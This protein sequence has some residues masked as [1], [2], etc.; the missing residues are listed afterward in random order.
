MLSGTLAIDT[1][2]GRTSEA[3]PSAGLSIVSE[4]LDILLSIASLH[5]RESRFAIHF[6]RLADSAFR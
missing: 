6:R 4:T 2:S 5:F 1:L 3:D